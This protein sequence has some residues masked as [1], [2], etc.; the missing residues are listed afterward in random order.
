MAAPVPPKVNEGRITNGKPNSWAISLPRRY[1]VQISAGAE[2]TPI[3]LSNCLNCSLSS[4]MLMALT[5]TPI[6]FTP[7]SAQIPFSSASKHKF[8]AVCPPIV[9]KTASI[10]GCALRISIIDLVVNGF[11]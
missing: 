5:S 8:K 9:G 10:W 3:F 2:G 1:E 4:V 6:N 11:K 7:K